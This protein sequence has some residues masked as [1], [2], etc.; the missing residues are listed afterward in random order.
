MSEWN[1]AVI[2]EFRQNEGKVAQFGDA[3][4]VILHTIGPGR[5]S[6]PRTNVGRPS[7]PRQPSC[8]SSAST[9]SPQRPD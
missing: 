5:S 1:D 2:K 7:M 6:S 8:P 3:P 9:S 4:L